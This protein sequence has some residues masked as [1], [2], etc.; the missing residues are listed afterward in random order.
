MPFLR[1]LAA[2]HCP[3]QFKAEPGSPLQ[4]GGPAAV[5]GHEGD[6]LSGWDWSAGKV[7]SMPTGSPSTCLFISPIF[8]SAQ[9][10]CRIGVRWVFFFYSVLLTNPRA[11][12][13]RGKC[14]TT[15]LQVP[16]QHT[17]AVKMLLKERRGSVPLKMQFFLSYF[18]SF[19]EFSAF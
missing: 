6:A 12:Y 5:S 14:Y 15:E 18:C 7:S 8:G 3:S 9:G 13:L 1:F 17:D 10:Y 19:E 4:L 16:H 11:S 2:L